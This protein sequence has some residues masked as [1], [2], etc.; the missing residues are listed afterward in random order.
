[1]SVQLGA[2][3][4]VPLG[5]GFGSAALTAGESRGAWYSSLSRPGWTPPSWV[6]GPVWTALYVMMGYA[7]YRVWRAGGSMR[8]YA[9]RLYAVQLVLNFAWSLIFFKGHD[10]GLATADILALLGVLTATTVQFWR[11]DPVAGALMVPYLAWTSYATALTISMYA[12]N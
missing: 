7:S 12:R 6:F 10:L 1:M 5:V 11:V 4:A 9:L 8:L 2:A 3:L